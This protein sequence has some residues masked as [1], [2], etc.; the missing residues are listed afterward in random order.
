[1]TDYDYDYDFFMIMVI[2]MI[3]IMF[4]LM[5]MFIK[6]IKITYALYTIAFCSTDCSKTCPFG[7]L[8]AACDACVCAHHVLT[9]R[10]LT[11][12]GAALSRAN[13]SLADAPYNVI[14]QSNVSGHFNVHG[15]CASRQ[16]F[17]VVRA[18]FVPL[19]LNS[20]QQSA[21]ESKLDAKLE[22]AGK[23][24]YIKDI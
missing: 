5:I 1:M 15:V 17:L 2:I 4:T 23:S 19:K 22:N 11:S 8:N 21:S 13:I 10:V 6:I 14:S 12:E 7:T 18:G 24:K 9:G 16:L 3:M 20:T